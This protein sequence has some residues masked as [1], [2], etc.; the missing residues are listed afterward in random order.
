MTY[1]FKLSPVLKQ[2]IEHTIK[3]TGTSKVAYE[4][5]TGDDSLWFVKDDGAY[6]MTNTTP[7]LMKPGEGKGCVVAYAEGA[8]PQDEWI[9]GDDFAENIPLSWFTEALKQKHT[10]FIITFSGETM[11]FTSK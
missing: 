5:K 2:L 7:R 10:I 4:E 8:T 1:V 9:G 11:R 3:H 6:L